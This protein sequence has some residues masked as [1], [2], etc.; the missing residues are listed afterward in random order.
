[1]RIVLTK[2]IAT[3]YLGT[4][5]RGSKMEVSGGV[6]RHLVDKGFA[7]EEELGGEYVT[8]STEDARPSRESL[9]EDSDSGATGEGGAAD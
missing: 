5:P 9:A 7:K 8:T 4:I 2:S 6:G 1:M 3:A